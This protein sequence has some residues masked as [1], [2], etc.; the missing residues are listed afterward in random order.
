MAYDFRLRV[1]RLLR[2]AK[3]NVIIVNW[4]DKQYLSDCLTSVF[5][6]AY[7]DFKVI[8][9]DNGSTDGS[10][11]FVK[12]NYSD[13]EIVALEK[14]YGFAKANNV[15]MERTLREGTNY[16][17]LLNNDIKVD[18]SW[19]GNLVKA[20]EP[21]NKMGICASKILKIA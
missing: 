16:I 12:E 3:V 17:T 1:V 19:L 14:N 6:Q 7:K 2:M 10:V 18:N 20:M 9:I 8:L 4:D 5:E 13:V 15:A 11:E 21:D